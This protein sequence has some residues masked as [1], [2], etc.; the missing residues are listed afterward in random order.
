L[1][2]SPSCSFTVLFFQSTLPSRLTDRPTNRH[3]GVPGGRCPRGQVWAQGLQ[4]AE[5]SSDHCS[6]RNCILLGHLHVSFRIRDDTTIG[7]GEHPI[8]RDRNDVETSSDKSSTLASYVSTQFNT[9]HEQLSPFLC[10][11]LMLSGNFVCVPTT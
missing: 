9:R 7:E 3:L 5:D 10:L 6:R 11:T 2:T 8:I 1:H 4:D